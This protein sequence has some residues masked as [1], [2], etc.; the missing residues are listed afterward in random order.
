MKVLYFGH[1]GGRSYGDDIG[2]DLLNDIF[3]EKYPQIQLDVKVIK[4]GDKLDISNRY[5]FYL[6]GCGTCVSNMGRYYAD[7][8]LYFPTD[9]LN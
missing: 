8:L 1:L 6:L 9:I 3:K 7:Q 2:F 4:A 5:D